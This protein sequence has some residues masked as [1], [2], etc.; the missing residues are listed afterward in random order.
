[1]TVPQSERVMGFVER[2]TTEKVSMTF[3][4]SARPGTMRQRFAWSEEVA[5]LVAFVSS[6]LASAIYGAAVCAN[7]GVIRSIV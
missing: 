1:V 6:P 5:A 3:L 4:C 2:L 7:G